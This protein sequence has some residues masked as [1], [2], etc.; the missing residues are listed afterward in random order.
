MTQST[1]NKYIRRGFQ[2]IELG[3]DKTPLK[4]RIGRDGKCNKSSEPFNSNKFYAVVPSKKLMIIDVDIKNGKKGLESLERLEA[5]LMIDLIPSVRTGSGG[6]HI[7]TLISEPIRILQKE[8]PDIDFICHKAN[9]KLCTPYAVAG[10]QTIQYDDKDYI[11]EILNDLHI[12]DVEGLEEL[13]EIDVLQVEADE[14]IISMDDLYEKKTSEEVIGLLNWLDA[15]DYQ[16]WMANASSIKRELGNTKE[17]FN[18]FDDWSKTADNYVDRDA[19]LKKWKEVGEYQSQPRTM[20]TLYMNAVANKINKLIANLNKCDD[21]DDMDKLLAK[22]EWTQYPKFTGEIIQNEITKSYQAQC[23]RLDEPLTYQQC[24]KKSKILYGKDQV[25]TEIVCEMVE[26]DEEFFDFVRVASFTRCPYF[27]I[28]NGARHDLEGVGMMLDKPLTKV[29][30]KLGL[31]KVMTIQQAFKKKLIQY[32]VNHEYNPM[33]NSRLFI[34]EDGKNVLNLFDPKTVPIETAITDEGKKLINKFRNHLSN[35]MSKDEAETF[36]DWMAYATQNPGKKLLWVPLI[37][38]VEGVGK[39]LIGNLLIN[40][41]FGKANAGVVDSVII[42]DKNNSWASSKMLRILEEIKLSGHNRYEVLN[43][44][45]P[46][47][48]NPTITRVEK[49]EVSSEVRNTCNFIAFTN[50]KDALPIDEHDRRWWLVFSPIDSLDELEKI[51]GQNRQ[52][53]FA[54][55]HELAKPQSVYGTEFRTFLLER[56]IEKFNPNFPPD[57]KHKEELAEI[58]R[59]KLTGIDEVQDLIT[60]IYK[61]D[62][63]KVI[64]LTLVREASEQAIGDTG[65][66]ITPRGVNPKEIRSVLKKLGYRSITKRDYAQAEWSGVSPMYYHSSTCTIPEA[67]KVW[68]AGHTVDFLAAQFD[69]LD[70]EL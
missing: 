67:V 41:V 44:L 37:Q 42:A 24:Q 17:A 32:A 68:E 53:Y 62:Q 12:N 38:S 40:H 4:K 61:N 28:S 33:T 8:Y 70:D 1:Y 60:F 16:D 5:D 18:I 49:F 58:E 2:L 36:L 20:A 69:N 34:D 64:N 9:T 6:L 43:Q 31:K 19:C 7:Y 13:L 50:F 51:V 59:S 14:E 10:E 35:L 22:D 48:T 21:I 23:Q 27:Q 30:Q 25:D 26:E 29:S 45:K 11:Y 66:R 3:E 15:S 63:P 55:L 54:P 56:N 52:E 65:K 47:I 39:S 46:L 57:S